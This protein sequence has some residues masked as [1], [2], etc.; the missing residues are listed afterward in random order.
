MEP[1]LTFDGFRIGDILE[2]LTVYGAT[3][4]KMLPE[5]LRLSQLEEAEGYSYRDARDSR[6]RRERRTPTSGDV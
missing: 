6:Q 2:E 4:V 5:D 1:L 3:S